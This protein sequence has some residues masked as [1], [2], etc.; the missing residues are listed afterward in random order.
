LTGFFLRKLNNRE[1]YMS[2]ADGFLNGNWD[3]SQIIGPTGPI[4]YPGKP[5]EIFNIFSKEDICI[6]S[7]FYFKLQTKD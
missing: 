6:F 7:Q 3:Y 1:A 2:Q 4:V 5:C